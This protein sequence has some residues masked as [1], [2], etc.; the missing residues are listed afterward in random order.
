MYNMLV[1]RGHI[2]PMRYGKVLIF[3]LTLSALFRW[4][5][6]TKDT[7]NIQYKMIKYKTLNIL[8]F[9]YLIL[10]IFCRALVGEQERHIAVKTHN[11]PPPTPKGVFNVKH[12]L[13]PHKQGCLKYTSQVYKNLQ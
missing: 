5:K 2:T 1:S 8:L 7:S 11:N 10:N 13:C 4:F 12:H 3:A 6:T 9:I